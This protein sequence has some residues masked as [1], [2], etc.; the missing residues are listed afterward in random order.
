MDLNLIPYNTGLERIVLPEYGRT[1]QQM[2]EYCLS[3]PDREER[4]VCASSI[5][6]TLAR[7]FPSQV[8]DH[9]DMK[10]FWDEINIISGFRLDVDFPVEVITQDAVHPTPGKVPYGAPLNHHRY[11]GKLIIAMIGEVADMP[12]GPAKDELISR[13]AHQMKKQMMLYNRKGV[14]DSKI[15]SDLAELSGGRIMLDPDTYLLHEFLEEVAPVASKG[16]VKKKKRRI[17]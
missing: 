11:Y 4:T 3:I 6:S 17:Y 12:D 1:V 15:L 16:K 5:V 7:L 8:G 10:K 2:V 13:V 9:R 14:P